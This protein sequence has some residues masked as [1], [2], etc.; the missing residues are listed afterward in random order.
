VPNPPIG[1]ETE[2]EIPIESE[3]DIKEPINGAIP[4]PSNPNDN[5]ILKRVIVVLSFVVGAI[6]FAIVVTTYKGNSTN[7]KSK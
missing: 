7:K 4:E 1:S 3:T 6:L 2:S 5:L